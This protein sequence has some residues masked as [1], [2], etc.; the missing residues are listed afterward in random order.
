MCTKGLSV[1]LPLRPT[2]A[3]HGCAHIGRQLRGRSGF[4][5][6]FPAGES[7]LTKIATAEITVFLSCA[8]AQGFLSILV[9]PNVVNALISVNQRIANVRRV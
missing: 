7:K 2:K 9:A 4:F 1:Q 8:Q 5:V 6:W 3:V